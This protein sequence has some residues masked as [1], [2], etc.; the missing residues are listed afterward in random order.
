[1]AGKGWAD[2]KVEYLPSVL[3]QYRSGTP[4]PTVR[5]VRN[6]V[7]AIRGYIEILNSGQLGAERQARQLRLVSQ[8]SLELAELVEDLFEDHH[9]V[10]I[11]NLLDLQ[12]WAMAMRRQAIAQRASEASKREV[13]LGKVSAR[14]AVKRTAK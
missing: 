2:D 8:K 5:R 1:V 11:G 6:L 7:T 13:R 12:Q 14:K 10:S 9:G 3:G 4:G